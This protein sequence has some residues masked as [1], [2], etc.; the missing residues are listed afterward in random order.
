[1]SL[2]A[3]RTVNF[4]DSTGAPGRRAN[5]GDR[6]KKAIKYGIMVYF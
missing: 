6:G 3:A 1:M 4:T 2:D 5:E